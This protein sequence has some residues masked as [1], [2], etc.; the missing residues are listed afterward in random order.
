M[1]LLRQKDFND[2]SVPLPTDATYLPTYPYRYREHGFITIL[3]VQQS[4]PL[5]LG[6][7]IFVPSINHSKSTWKDPLVHCT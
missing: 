5:V 6:A 2:A 4:M 1:L 7:D 3:H